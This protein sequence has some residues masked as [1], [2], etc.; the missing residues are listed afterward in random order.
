MAWFPMLGLRIFLAISHCLCKYKARPE[1]SLILLW[2]S[3]GRIF[4]SSLDTLLAAF[5]SVVNFYFYF[6]SNPSKSLSLFPQRFIEPQ[7]S[8][9]ART[10]G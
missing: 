10:Q 4:N 8:T 6:N 9:E 1:T 5:I 7:R 2:Q 3:L